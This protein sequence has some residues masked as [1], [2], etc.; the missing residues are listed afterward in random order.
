MPG[1]LLAPQLTG[2]EARPTGNADPLH[3][4]HGVYR[5]AGADRWLAIAV[6]S[7]A[8][9][10]ALCGVVPD[11]RDRSGL[12]AE[13]R[14]AARPEIDARLAAWARI[15]DDLEAMTALQAAGV[16][17]S[18]SYTTNDLFGDAHLWE[19]GFYRLVHEADG[20]ARFLPGLPW[21]WGD[22]TLIEPRAA[23]AQGQDSERVLRDLAGLS[24]AEV[25]AL[26]RAGAFG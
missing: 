6:T 11:L 2:A 21:R 17:A 19:R 24:P 4:P 12:T 15:R 20:T 23:P 14:R 5:C 7:D 3:A 9:W 8:E 18:A 1:A 22:G 10:R 13:E 25:E 16:P 26:R